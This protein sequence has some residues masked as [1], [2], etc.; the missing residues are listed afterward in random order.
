VQSPRLDPDVLQ[1]P[2]QEGEF[3]PRVVITFQVMAVSGVSPGYPD[4]VGS[5][6]KGGQNELGVHSGGAGHTDD[7]EMGRVL[8]AAHACQV[9]RTVAAPVAQKGRDFRFPITHASLQ[10]AVI[11]SSI[12]LFKWLYSSPSPAASRLLQVAGLKK[13]RNAHSP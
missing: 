8:E 13:K 11:V 12:T 4:P 1:Q 10:T 7:S 5:I 9:R 2:F 3:S 6:A